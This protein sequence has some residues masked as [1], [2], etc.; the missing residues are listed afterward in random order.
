MGVTKKGDLHVI[1]CRRDTGKLYKNYCYTYLAK[2]QHPP[3]NLVVF[4][5]K[6]DHT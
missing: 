6:S 5:E 2:Y 4:K 1:R 3:S